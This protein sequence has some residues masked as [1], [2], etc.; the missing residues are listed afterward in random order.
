MNPVR[1][2]KDSEQLELHAQT[3]ATDKDVIAAGM[4]CVYLHLSK[5]AVVGQPYGH[6]Q[7]HYGRLKVVATGKA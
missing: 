2:L 7:G 5:S 3:L 1:L 4:Y 6:R